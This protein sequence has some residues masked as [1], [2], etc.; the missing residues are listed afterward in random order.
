MTKNQYSEL[1]KTE[2][3]PIF[4]QNWWLDTV[5]G[6]ENW[7]PILIF[8]KNN[9]IIG[10]SFY[11]NKIRY[12]FKTITQ[13]ILTPFSGVWM[14][15]FTGENERKKQQYEADILKEMAEK[16]PKVHFFA[17][18]FHFSLTN[19]LP[20]HWAGFKNSIR[21]TYFFKDINDKNEIYKNFNENVTRNIKK[22]ENLVF[23]PS[24]DVKTLYNLYQ[25]SLEHAKSKISFSFH[26]LNLLYQ[27]IKENKAGQIFEIKNAENQV[28]SACLLVWD[29][30]T[31]YLLILG[32][33]RLHQGGATSLIWQ[34][35]P[36]LIAK[37]IKNLDLEG[38]MLPSVEKFYRSLGAERKP[39]FRISKTSNKLVEA[40]LIL[41]N[42]I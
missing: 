20:L 27:A 42:K 9:Q 21:Y 6:T 16:L 14:R 29:K 32:N 39:Y 31:A 22:G 33:S 41:M 8:D 4:L 25:N 17:Q 34:L 7:Q 40:L 18:N 26:T 36:Y 35:F 13:P 19:I 12:G 11:Y 28:V 24:D 5:C 2:S 1:C 3:L 37:N 15:P 38:S 10:A 30:E 23:E